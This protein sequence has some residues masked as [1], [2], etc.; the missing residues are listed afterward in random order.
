MSLN[1]ASKYFNSPKGTLHNKIKGKV[2]LQ[3]KMR[4]ENVLKV[5]NE[6]RIDKWILDKSKLGFPMHPEDVKDSVQ[7]I[8]IL[9]KSKLG[10][11]MHP[12]DVKDSVQDILKALVLLG[13]KESQVRDT[14]NEDYAVAKRIIEK[15][16][17]PER[18]LQSKQDKSSTLSKSLESIFDVWLICEKH[19]PEENGTL[20]NNNEESVD[21]EVFDIDSLPVDIID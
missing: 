2:P 1:A 3:R 20:V 5:G 15:I 18:S 12:E 13:L 11:P 8:L 9:D 10:F 16:I 17:G 4:P 19:A 6:N 14:S 7:D 21:K